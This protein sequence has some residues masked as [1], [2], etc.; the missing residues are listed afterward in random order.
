[1]NVTL[2]TDDQLEQIV[3][4]SIQKYL[5]RGAQ[6][7]P[8]LIS[9][10]EAAKILKRS[11]QTIHRWTCYGYKDIPFVKNGTRITFNKQEL[12]SWAR[13]FGMGM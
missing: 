9:S 6:A 5:A 3:E 7:Y 2:L 13:Q 10:G 4:K 8:E 12:L 1:M 11:V